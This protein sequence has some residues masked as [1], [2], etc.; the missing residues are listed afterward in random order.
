[1]PKRFTQAF[2]HAA[3]AGE[4]M[5]FPFTSATISTLVH[6]TEDEQRVLK[7]LWLAVPEG[8]EV[9]RTRVRGHFGNPIVLLQVK[10]KRKGAIQELWRKILT[11]LGRGGLEELKRD[12][13]RKID[14]RC[15]LYLRFDKQLAHR[16]ELVFTEGGDAVHFKLKVAAFPPKPEAAAES[17]KGFLGEIGK[18]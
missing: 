8:V 1:M 10:V 18:R 9:N 6:A 2:V 17:V 5:G 15:N 7:A 4:P 3:A 14:D 16:G 12:L 13:P 11:N